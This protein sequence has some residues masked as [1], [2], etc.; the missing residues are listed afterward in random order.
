[1]AIPETVFFALCLVGLAVVVVLIQRRY[2]PLRKTPEYL[3]VSTFLPLFISCSIVVLVPI[4]LSSNSSTQDGSRG[5]V[6]PS[7][8]LLVA[9]R[10]SYW[11]CF[12]LTWAI[13]PLLISYSDSG[14]RSPQKRFL[15]ALRENARYHLIILS[16]GSIGL[17]YFLFAVGLNFTALKGLVI[18]LSHSYAL[19][20]AIFLMGHGLVAVPRELFYSSSISGNLRRLQ[21]RAPPTYDKLL[22]ATHTVEELEA[23]VS[24]LRHRKTGSAREFQDWIEELCELLSLP[25]NALPGV[26]RSSRVPQVITEEYLAS[27]TARLKAALHRRA[28]FQREWETLVQS[29]ADAQSILDSSS[30]RRLN[31]TPHFTST[32]PSTPISRITILSPYLRHILHLH[33]LPYLRLLGSILLSLAST[34]IIWTEIIHAFFPRLSLLPY[35][36]I[37]HP[38]SSHGAIGLAGQAI[39]AVWLLYMILAAYHSLSIVK[40]W[41]TYCLVPRMTSGSSAAFYSSYAARLTVPLAFNFI[42]MIPKSLTNHED[43]VFY[44][45]LGHLV[46][47][48][49]ISEG[50][51]DYFPVVILVPVLA[52][53]GNWYRKIGELVGFGDVLQDDEDEG[54]TAGA[55]IEGRS[56]IERELHGAGRSRTSTRATGTGS[57]GRRV[58]SPIAGGLRSPRGGR[59]RDDPNNGGEEEAEESGW[60]AWMHRVR[61]TLETV[62]APRWLQ[63]QQRRQ[64]PRRPAD[65]RAGRGTSGVR[66]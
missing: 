30:S 51:N 2:L 20:L 59:Y 19:S 62:E 50:W 1:M 54:G 11:L 13:L 52:A 38:S 8:L 5:I 45:F 61:N 15:Q 34:A 27:L 57:A 36:F 64:Q 39:A 31:F 28:R 56:L 60:G 53:L 32:S 18:A 48:T 33:I 14:H 46:N 7:R 43:T 10:I 49:A 41:G 65:R 22:D 63:Q 24:V 21:I 17:V 12:V 47:L 29:A 35:T 58:L 25:E 44:K 6:L 26:Q 55:W 4:D 3:L 23:E 40:V 16:L 37:H 66:S 9:W 42:S